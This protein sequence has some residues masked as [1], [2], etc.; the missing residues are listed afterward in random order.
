MRNLKNNKVAGTDW[1]YPELIKCGGNK[2]LNKIY[3]LVRRI[4]GEERIPEEWKETIIVCIYKKGD[5]DRCENY[6]G[7]AL[8]N[9]T[10]RILVNIILENIKPYIEKITGDYQNRFRDGRSVIDN[11]FELKIIN[12][13][14]WEYNQTAQYLFI[15]FQKA[16]DSIHTDMLWKCKEEFKIPKKLINMCKTCVQKT[17]SAVRLEGTLSSFSENKTG[18]KQGDFLTPILFK[19]AL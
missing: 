10:Y 1:I 4:W 12:G 13:K 11:I 8:G 7:I 19:L 15:D 14:I 2:L 17:R 18:L 3:E 6:R 5:R 16:Y 9:A